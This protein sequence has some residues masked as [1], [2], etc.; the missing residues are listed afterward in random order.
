MPK[1]LIPILLVILLLSIFFLPAY[2]Q[3]DAIYP[4]RYSQTVYFRFDRTDIDSTYAGNQSVLD[5]LNALF[6][7]SFRVSFIDT[8][9]ISAFSSPE[10]SE[11]YNFR[12]SQQRAT[13]IKKYLTFH[14]PLLSTIPLSLIPGGENWE[15]LQALVSA[16]PDFNER[17]EVLMI[18]DKVHDPVKRE[19][20][21]KRLNG[22]RAY[23]YMQQHILP[24]LRNAIVCTFRMNSRLKPAVLSATSLQARPAGEITG[25]GSNAAQYPGFAVKQNTQT[26]LHI[27]ASSAAPTCSRRY[28]VL[29]TN[30][31]AWAMTTVNLAYEVQVGR[32][33]SL[34]LPVMWSSW[35]LAHTPALRIILFQPELRYWLFRPGRGHF[36]G[37]HAHV[38]R[39][40][41]KWEEYRYQ[42][43]GYPLLGAGVGYGY[44]LPL[45]DRWGMEFNLGV[46]YANSRYDTYHNVINGQLRDT[47]LLH[48]WG[49]T[50]LGLS[51]IYKL[52]KP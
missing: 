26:I 6:T 52:S 40:N 4:S 39:Y 50:R 12:L 43:T 1:P 27:A 13:T 9:L 30:L 37:L 22:G 24:R 14:Y 28:S 2:G 17:E 32:H 11:V 45:T 21:L 51:F 44:A 20:L 31:A 41:L 47:R 3:E 23:R 42:D 16:A 15:E 49:I 29:K 48:Y 36:L 33:F 5:A 8:I 19:R 7:D 25:D 35:D 38:A 34:D 10:G 18:L 46:G